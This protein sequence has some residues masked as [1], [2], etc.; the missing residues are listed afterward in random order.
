M[1]DA[2]PLRGTIVLL[3]PRLGI[4]SPRE[5]E[6]LL[7]HVR[8]GGTFVY[9][10]PLREGIVR[11]SPLMVVLGLRF[12]RGRRRL[13]PEDGRASWANHPLTDGLPRANSPRF[14]FELIP[15]EEPDSAAAE[16]ELDSAEAETDP[17]SDQDDEQDPDDELLEL[18][19][20]FPEAPDAGPPEPLLTASDS[21]GTEVMVAALVPLG[22]GRIVILADAAPVANGVAGSDPLAVLAVRAALAYT[23]EADT[24][25]FDEFHQG[26]TGYG[27]RAQVLANFFLGSPGGRT[28]SHVVLVAFLI[29][30]CKGLRFGVPN[31]AVAPSDRE[32]RSPLEHV[33]ALGDLY[34][35]AGAANTA[36]LLLLSRL[37]GAIRRPP[38]RDMDE[39]DGLLRE[40]EARGGKHPSSDRVYEGLH[41]EPVD[42][43]LVAAGVDEHLAR[44]YSK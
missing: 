26:I 9:A 33:S 39:A 18:P 23:S 30:A 21:S 7:D 3:A 2:D 25:F 14:G 43:T 40:I 28:L 37:S 15:E 8:E 41:A 29:L 12:P 24:V 17:D 16:A 22:E 36:A 6:A 34:R 19:R 31:T 4:L 13:L 1:V 5:M 38:P 44:R 11:T 32:R 35:Q 10:P 42:L 20:G 27:S